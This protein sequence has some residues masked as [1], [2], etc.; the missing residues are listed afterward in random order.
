[1]FFIPIA[2]W[3]GDPHITVGYYIWKSM[4][5]ALIGNI[6]GGGFFVGVVY[7]YMFLTGESTPI[8]IDGSIFE[9]DEKPLVGQSSFEPSE[10]K[11]TAT[12]DSSSKKSAEEMV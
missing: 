6:I 3:E 2:I 10:T 4:I 12:V 9:D 7:W 5:P 11:P 1:M 8:P